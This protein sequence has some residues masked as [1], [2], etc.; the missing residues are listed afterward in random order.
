MFAILLELKVR[1]IEVDA[2]GI[3]AE[4]IGRIDEADGITLKVRR[5]PYAMMHEIFEAPTEE[6]ES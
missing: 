2:S 6:L 3:E 1:A 4:C 5:E